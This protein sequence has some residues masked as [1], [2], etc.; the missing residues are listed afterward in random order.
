MPGHGRSDHRPPGAAY[1]FIDYVYDVLNAADALG[2]ERFAL[3]GHSLGAGIAAFVA[4][5]APERIMRLALIEGFGPRAGDPLEAPTRLMKALAQARA[6]AAKRVPV[7]R[8][9]QAAAAARAQ[10]SGLN[11]AAAV[12]LAERGT[13]TVPGGVGWRSDP[14]LTLLSPLYLTESQVLAFL[15]AIRA[16]TLLI[17]AESGL[18]REREGSMA[19]R[20]RCVERLRIIDLPGSHHLHLE[21]PAPTARVLSEFFRV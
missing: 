17:R 3:L 5:V 16:P 12:T 7:Y 19:E 15:G 6:L 8:D 9:L 4:A 11:L 21:D 13:Q 14:R 10:A 18:L 1:H 20:Y 2:W